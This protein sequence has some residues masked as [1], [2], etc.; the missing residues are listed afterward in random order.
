MLSE[1][2]VTYWHNHITD[3][4]DVTSRMQQG[5]SRARP[6]GPLHKDP[7]IKGNRTPRSLACTAT[8]ALWALLQTA[9]SLQTA[10]YMAH[11]WH[12]FASRTLATSHRTG[13][14]TSG[15]D[16]AHIG[17]YCLLLPQPSGPNVIFKPLEF[18]T[19]SLT[20]LHH[21]YTSCKQ[22]M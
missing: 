17:I 6:R 20:N 2:S 13:A 16:R 4:M 15:V 10:V 5:P 7:Y 3:V 14:A 8:I 11:I 12:G 9:Q 18:L 21:T 1:T 22:A 19:P